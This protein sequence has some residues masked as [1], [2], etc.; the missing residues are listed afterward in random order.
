M[1]QKNIMNAIDNQ[2]VDDY[3]EMKIYMNR[4]NNILKDVGLDSRYE[5]YDQ[6]CI[7]IKKSVRDLMDRTDEIDPMS[8]IKESLNNMI[9]NKIAE[10]DD[11]EEKLLKFLENYS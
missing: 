8:L 11:Y 6:F 4:I 7:D 5:N 1:D 10:D 3:K 2:L 9:I